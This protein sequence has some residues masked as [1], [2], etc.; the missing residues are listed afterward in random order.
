MV[1]SLGRKR[2]TLIMRDDW[3]PLYTWVY[4][5]SHKSDAA[6]LFE[7]F[8]ADSRAD[9]VSSTVVLDR[10]DGGDEFRG[11]KFGDLCRSRGIKQELTKADS[12]QFNGEAKSAL[13]WIDRPPWRAESRLKSFFPARNSRPLRRCGRNRP[14]GCVTP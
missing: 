4:V 6:L 8:L 2:Y 3:F 10:S 9:G 14:S 1:E 7:Q 13:G 11:G 12:P 5:M